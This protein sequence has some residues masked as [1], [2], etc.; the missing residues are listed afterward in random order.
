[1]IPLGERLSLI[2]SLVPQGAAV[3]DIG[4]DHG[5][6][7]VYLAKSGRAR[8][9]ISADLRP[10]PLESARKNAARYG[11]SL[12]FRL[13]DGLSGISSGEADTVI[14]AGMGGEVIA[15]IIDRCGWVKSS[16]VLLILQA[17]TSAEALRDYLAENGFSA[18]SETAAA[19]G[20]RAY[21]VICAR[22]CGKPRALSPA[23]RYIGEI[24]PETA[25]GRAYIEKQYKRLSVCAGDIE[26]IPQRRDEYNALSAAVREIERLYPMCAEKQ[27]KNG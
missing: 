20:K 10:L 1:M 14:I 21:S 12:D 26:N 11:V 27:L 16:G 13:C 4:C 5:Y 2:A 23:E 8:S 24:T 7:S 15:G 25:P 9:V 3:C 19:E 6:L 17:M 22:F 18:E